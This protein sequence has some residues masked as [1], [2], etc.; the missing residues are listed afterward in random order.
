MR[1]RFDRIGKALLRGALEPAGTVITEFEVP[2]VDAQ[3]ADVW[4]EPA[5]DPRARASRST[6]LDRMASGPTLFEPFHDPPGLDEM[7]D[8]LRKQLTLDHHRALDARKQGRPRP[9][10][11]R[12]WTLSTGRPEGV[13]AGYGLTPLAGFPT[14]FYEGRPAESMGAVV[15]RELPRERST[16]LLRLLGSGAVLQQALEELKR[17][18]AGAWEREVALPALVAARVEMLHDSTDESDREFLMTTQSLY[19]KLIEDTLERGRQEGRMAALSKY[20]KLI[21]D[22]LERGRQE[23][24]MAALS[25]YDQLIEDTLERGRQEGRMAA[26]RKYDQLIEA[27]QERGRQEGHAEEAKRALTLLYQA[28]FGPMPP[29]LSGALEATRDTATLERWLVLVGTRPEPEV[30]AALQ[31]DPSAPE[32]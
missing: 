28:R 13:I 3:A 12:L 18:P 10:F 24:R 27:T 30:V 2:A 11:P 31:V 1:N 7:R 25:K 26:Q 32:R 14:G 17:L 9:P 5:P 22:T 4:F 20:D 21:E 15:L 16:L 29:A 23:G 19:D 6:L 8:C